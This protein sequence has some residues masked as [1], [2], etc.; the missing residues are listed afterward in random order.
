MQ[1]RRRHHAYR[2]GP[3]R[4]V[5]VPALLGFAVAL[6][7]TV[8]APVGGPLRAPEARAATAFS[9]PSF[10]EYTVFSGLTKPMTVRFAPDGRAFVAEKAGVIK[11]YDSV[12]DTTP[13]TVI[14]LGPEV[15]SYWD[16]GILGI[17]V[18]PAFPTRPYLYVFYVY[19]A[20][21][22]QTAPAWNDACAA[23]PTGPGGTVDGC[24][25][26]SRLVRIEIDPATNA[27]VGSPVQLVRDWCQQYPSHSGGGIAFGAD[28][29]L[30]VA[31]GDGASFN[32]S[33]YGQGGGTSPDYTNPY[34][35]VNPCKDPVKVTSSVGQKPTVDVPS[36]EGGALRSQDIR[37][38]ADSVGLSGSI[39][40]VNPDTG[41]ASGGNPLAS[42]SSANARR[43]IAHGF[44]N[45][46]RMTFRPGTNDLWVGNVGNGTWEEIERVA[47]PSSA[48]TA[49]T[50]P[51]YGWPCYEA[52]EKT[53]F[54][55]LGNR[56][57]QDLYAAGTAAHAKPYYAYSHKAAKLPTGPCFTP[58][59]NGND[60]GAPSGLAFYTGTGSATPYP[61]RYLGALFFVDY[62]RRCLA[63]LPKGSNGL[64]D[65][66]GMQVVG[67]DLAGPVDL[68]TAPGGDLL[69]VDHN[70]GRVVGI[71]YRVKPVARATATPEM[72]LAPTTI[73]LDATASSD[74][75][76]TA[77]LVAW[78]WDL[79]ADGAYDDATGAT[80]EWDVTTEAV[81][82]VGLE[83]QS[84]NGLKDT[85]TVTVDTTNDPPVPVIDAP[86][87]GLTWSVGDE[88]V[89][90]GHGTDP[91]DGPLPG[92]ALQWDIVMQHCPAACHAHPVETINGATASFTA[93]DHEYPSHLEIR[94]TATDTDGAARTT[95]LEI[96]PD[97][98][99]LRI[100]STPTGIGIS[101]G[102]AAVATP[103]ETTLLR[104]G[105]VQVAPPLTTTVGGV[106]HRFDRWADTTT[107]VRDLVVTDPT[108]LAATYVPDAGDTCASATRGATSTWISDRAS[109]NGDVDW[110]RF[111]LDAS[112]RVVITAGDLP[113]DA[114]LSLY[115]SCSASRIALTDVAGT[116]YE[117]IV[118]VL[119]AGTY[120]VKVSYAAR[121]S[122]PYV[123]RFRPLASG[124][125]VKSSRTS[126]GAG[127]GGPVRIVG[128]LINNSGSTTGR[129]SVTATFRDG[130]GTVVG[131]L[132]GS[133][134]ANRLARGGVTPF[135]LS[136]SVPAYA[137]VRLTVKAGTAGAAR[138]LAVTSATRTA[139][140][141]GTVTEKGTVRNT[142]TI[143]LRNVGVALTWYGRRG[144]VLERGTA[145]VS[146]STLGAGASGSYTIIRPALEGVQ[147]T[148]TALRAS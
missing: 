22:G 129:A 106:R 97:T 101:L 18:D 115:G 112:R 46:Y 58:D 62:S 39:I 113:V 31:A 116:R 43:I 13:V 88:I 54:N 128:E 71:A 90:Q 143:T 23:P 14:D 132:T 6:S 103:S 15:M 110:F 78:R 69:Y 121:S 70:G 120:R 50:M 9:D 124:I 119:P 89:L 26:S 77:S 35:T 98:T 28:G 65:P 80:Y 111:S 102:G 87:A 16:R 38:T 4:R 24:P 37:T 108:T 5:L 44:R 32:W 68:V 100:E 11:A 51:N 75:D 131:T 85:G 145:A 17:A 127:G 138:S 10:R 63:M 45:P 123:V 34:V 146:P 135:A 66:T 142:G 40:R 73:T 82:T 72:A 30:Y 104:G 60:Q 118:R 94:L 42:S 147:A 107:R 126:L 144:E 74:P 19:D 140:Q 21:L 105:S 93:P 56:L 136:G 2:Q 7:T 47:V 141:D 133:S 137:S 57:C 36:A 27:A 1:P 25:V 125:V 148:R 48:R 55:T 53:F 3:V 33:D 130:A 29:Q 76:P 64:P 91:Q 49:T 96:D 117:E 20:P 99:S 12:T 86:A 61:S 83:V 92:T 139:N 8:A 52:L 41:A 114:R 109:G 84:S 59:A 81:W 122:S 79:D 134:F 95:S 67:T